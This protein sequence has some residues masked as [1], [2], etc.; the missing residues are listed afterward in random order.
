[1]NKTIVFCVDAEHA[2]QMRL[3]LHRANAD[4]TRQYPHYVARIVSAEG[5]V[6][7]GPSPRR[8]VIGNVFSGMV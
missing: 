1:M 2:E 4:L 3:A 8:T 5:D 7:G 6:F